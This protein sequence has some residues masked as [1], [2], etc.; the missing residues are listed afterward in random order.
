MTL[1]YSQIVAQH[2]ALQKEESAEASPERVE[3][4]K[5]F[6][7]EVVAA[8]ANIADPRQRE[9]LRNFLRYWSAYVYD[10]TREY[11]PSQLIP[12]AGTGRGG[13]RFGLRNFAPVLWVIAGVIL[14]LLVILGSKFFTGL[15]GGGPT[16]ES[17]SGTPSAAT[18]PP[19]ETDTPIPEATVT[20]NPS[21]T[22]TVTSLPTPTE[23]PGALFSLPS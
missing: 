1:S 7:A 4:V 19:T 16:P 6:I 17:T 23:V 20:P 9:Q 8:G 5:A 11:P 3:R 22:V 21:P 12:F 2:Q 15:T 10:H 14:A 13:S 18:Q